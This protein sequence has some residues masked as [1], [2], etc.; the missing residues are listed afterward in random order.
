[1]GEIRENQQVKLF[2][3]LSDGTEKELNCS[4]KKFEEDRLSLNFPHETMDYIDYL[5]EG[6]E[7]LAKVFAPT[8]VKV[9][10]SIILNSPIEDEF[11]IEYTENSEQI[12]RRNFIRVA[13]QTKMVISKMGN[14]D[15]VATTV[16]IGGGGIRFFY[17]GEFNDNEIVNITL[18][19]PLEMQSVRAEAAILKKDYL[20]EYEHV[21][22]FNKITEFERS[23]IIKLCNDIQIGKLEV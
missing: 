2:F 10:D 22:I 14:K 18:F 11:V 19:L 15:V 20:S 6:A 7:I 16:D 3:I 17:E 9:F 8:G 5:D 12:Q 4:I 23:K 13:F 1:M 21:L